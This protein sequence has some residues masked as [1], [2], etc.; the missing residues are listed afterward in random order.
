MPWM[1]IMPPK[2]RLYPKRC[3]VSRAGTLNV[4]YQSYPQAI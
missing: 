4:K 2:S 3:Y 1:S